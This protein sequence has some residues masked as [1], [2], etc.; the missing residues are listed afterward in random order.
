MFDTNSII[1]AIDSIVS[2][3]VQRGISQ[4]EMDNNWNTLIALVLNKEKIKRNLDIYEN[5]VK[6]G[7]EEKE[8]SDAFKLL[9][10][11]NY[12]NM[13]VSAFLHINLSAIEGDN[14]LSAVTLKTPNG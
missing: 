7:I 11:H 13:P 12:T 3:S 6:R 14:Y 4:Q 10:G 9:T 1:I 8:L 5:L 2:S